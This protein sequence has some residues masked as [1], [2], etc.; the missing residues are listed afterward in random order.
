MELK[1]INNEARKIVVESGGRHPCSLNALLCMPR[2]KGGRGL[3][4][5]EM[6]YKATKI[7]GV[8]SGLTIGKE[9]LRRRP[10]STD[11]FVGN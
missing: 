8:V 1:E 2:S 11:P 9:G 7:K 3:R 10:L 6:E 4:S 5:V